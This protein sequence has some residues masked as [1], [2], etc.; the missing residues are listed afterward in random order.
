[1][2]CCPV[3]FV[4]AKPKSGSKLLLGVELKPKIA[5][6][7]TLVECSH[8]QF[9]KSNNC[10]FFHQCYI[11]SLNNTQHWNHYW[12][13]HFLVDSGRAQPSWA[14]RVPLPAWRGRVSS[15]CFRWLSDQAE[16]NTTLELQVG[17]VDCSM[18]NLQFYKGAT[19]T[20]FSFFST[21]LLF[22]LFPPPRGR[23]S[24]PIYSL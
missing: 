4:S 11:S 16:P 1:M 20:F 15:T 9:Q 2:S 10:T 19:T 8:N 22:C 18:P 7:L 24:I 5:Q 23:A 17:N 14:R 12:Y 13:N 6:I 3:Q 21:V